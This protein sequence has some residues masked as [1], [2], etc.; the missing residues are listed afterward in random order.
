MTEADAVLAAWRRVYASGVYLNGPEVEN[1]ERELADF[2]GV[3]HALGVASGTAALTLALEAVDVRGREV[4]I[5]ALTFIATAEAVVHAGG[6]PVF[7]DVDPETWCMTL[8]T[9]R[10]HDS[11]RVAAIVPVDLFGNPAPIPELRALGVPIIED[12]CQALGASL[13]GVRCGALGDVAALSF[14]P[15]KVLAGFGDGGAVLTD[16]DRI[17]ESVRLA[18][19]HGSAD[20]RRHEEVG[21]T[22]RLDEIQAAGLRVRLEQL[23]ARLAQHQARGSG[24]QRVT[25]G[26]VSACHQTVRLGDGPGRRFYSPPVHLQPAM[27]RFYRGQ[28]PVAE[29]FARGNHAEPPIAQPAGPPLD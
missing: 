6:I 18:R 10:P 4:L 13:G 23:P 21:H 29:R 5:P 27:S 1:F 24:D 19:H 3:R 15:S 16:D 25:E 8:A 7:T 28:L 2:V 9:A 12:A 11:K 14:Y 17:A 22:A 20:G 26:G